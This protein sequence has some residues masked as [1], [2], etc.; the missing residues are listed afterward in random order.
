MRLCE[1]RFDRHETGVP[2]GG[3]LPRSRGR[4]PFA[5][6]D[7]GAAVERTARGSASLGFH[8]AGAGVSDTRQCEARAGES[9]F[10]ERMTCMAP[11]VFSPTGKQTLP[12]QLACTRRMVLRLWAHK[13]DA[14]PAGIPASSGPMPTGARKTL[15][16]EFPANVMTAASISMLPTSSTRRIAQ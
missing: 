15:A 4:C 7:G 2:D 3:P 9:W 10:T 11:Q 12:P 16:P 13:N 8:I 6:V 5:H 1:C 14:P